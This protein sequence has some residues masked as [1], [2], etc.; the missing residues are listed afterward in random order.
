MLIVRLE[1]LSMFPSLVLPFILAHV[2]ASLTFQPLSPRATTRTPVHFHDALFQANPR[3]SSWG[4]QAQNYDSQNRQEGRHHGDRTQR[5]GWGVNHRSLKRLSLESARDYEEGRR[6]YR[7]VHQSKLTA[8]EKASSWR[9]TWEPRGPSWVP[10]EGRQFP[11]LSISHRSQYYHFLGES[12]VLPPRLNAMASIVSLAKRKVD[13]P[14]FFAQP[15]MLRLEARDQNELVDMNFIESLLN[16]PS[17]AVNRNASA[18]ESTISVD[19]FLD[20]KFREKQGDSPRKHDRLRRAQVSLPLL[21]VVPRWSR[22]MTPG[23][24]QLFKRNTVAVRLLIRFG[25]ANGSDW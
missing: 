2:G 25:Y 22:V 7:A 18:M 17:S 14:A 5:A 10:K 20:P 23:D 6:R 19:S 11:N 1:D 21:P 9:G 24:K 4:S 12:D 8:N 3:G 15:S 16:P 13:I